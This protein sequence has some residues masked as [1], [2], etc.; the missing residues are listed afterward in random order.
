[1]LRKVIVL[2]SCVL[3]L[4]VY[5][6]V[7]H[8]PAKPTR[9]V[10]RRTRPNPDAGML[11]GVDSASNDDVGDERVHTSTAASWLLP[12]EAQ[13]RSV[14]VLLFAYGDPRVVHTFLKEA[15]AAALSIRRY[16]QNLS[17]AVVTNNETVD[18]RTRHGGLLFTHVIRPRHDLL[19]AGSGLQA[20]E[21][22]SANARESMP[23]QWTTRIL[24]MAL[25][26]FAITWAL[27]A[28]CGLRLAACGLRLALHVVATCQKP[29]V[30]LAERG[31]VVPSPSPPSRSLCL[32]CAK[33]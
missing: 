10:L 7:Y 11:R 13:K 26:P 9:R 14:G 31:A 1:M 20:V 27:G 8:A 21:G 18:D 28:P 22:H 32:P 24:Y 19:F 25:S 17:I 16:N 29:C 6:R 3:L 12:G 5:T 33:G 23:K 30:S 15:R 4:F 2:S